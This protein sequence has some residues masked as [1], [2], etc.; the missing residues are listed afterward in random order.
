MGIYSSTDLILTQNILILG[1]LSHSMNSFEYWKGFGTAV[2]SCCGVMTIRHYFKNQKK[3][4]DQIELLKTGQH[5][6]LKTIENLN[7][8]K[9]IDES[10]ELKDKIDTEDFDKKLKETL[11]DDTKDNVNLEF[12]K[13]NEIDIT[14]DNLPETKTKQKF[15]DFAILSE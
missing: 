8:G 7:S 6:L 4:M 9:S 2:I 1:F 14:F 10:K 5:E 13:L 12:L 15:K 11:D 3:L